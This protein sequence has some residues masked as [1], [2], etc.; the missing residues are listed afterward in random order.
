MLQKEMKAN[1]QLP[2]KHITEAGK[3]S[4]RELRLIAIDRRK[5]KEIVDNLCA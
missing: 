5:W 2:E 1:E 3:S 4:Y